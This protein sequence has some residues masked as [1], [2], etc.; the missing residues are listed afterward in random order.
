MT[1]YTA[2]HVSFTV[3]LKS[4]RYRWRRNNVNNVHWLIR[5]FKPQ[6]VMGRMFKIWEYK[7]M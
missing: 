6:N 7:Y 4:F 1:M 3:V 5:W 2:E